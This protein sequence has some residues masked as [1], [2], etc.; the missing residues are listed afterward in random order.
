[1]LPP[2]KRNSFS[3]KTINP[4]IRR[5][6]DER[7]TLDNTQ[8][9]AMPFVKATTTVKLPNILGSNSVG[10]TLGVQTL[11]RDIQLRDI[12][13]GVD[14]KE[15]VGYT[16][17]EQ[18]GGVVTKPIFAEQL[19]GAGTVNRF[20]DN[21]EILVNDSRGF[22]FIPPPGITSVTVGTNRQGF[23]RF[24][25][26]TISI[27]TRLQLEMLHRTFLLPGCGLVLEW[28]QQFAPKEIF[29]FGETGLEEIELFPWYDGEAK[30]R[31]YL[32]R[33]GKNQVGLDEIYEKYVIPSRG[34][35]NWTYGKIVSFNLNSNSDGSFE[36]KIKTVGSNENSLAY[37][38]R[39]TY[40][41]PTLGEVTLHDKNSIE[42]YFNKTVAGAKNFKSVL[43]R[44]RNGRILPEWRG[45]V[46]YFSQGNKIE[47]IS[48]EPVDAPNVDKTGFQDSEDA[49]FLTWRFF[50]NVILNDE[51]FGVKSIFKDKRLTPEQLERVS[52]LR[53][54][55]N[56]VG[57]DTDRYIVDP[58][59]N[60]V[61]NNKYL[62][63]I[64]PSTL[65]IVNETAAKESNKELI[66]NPI[67]EEVDV[68]ELYPITDESKAFLYSGSGDFYN[69]GDRPEGSNIQEVFASSLSQLGKNRDKGFLS[70]GVWINHKAVI[71]CILGAPTILEGINKLLQR[72][73]NATNNYWSLAIDE[74]DPV[75]EDAGNGIATNYGIVDMN[76]ADSS[77]IAVN[78]FLK[79]EET[80]VHVFNKYI[81]EQNG[82]IVG[83]DTIE[84]TVNLDLPKLLFSQ[85]S[86]LGITQPKDFEEFINNENGGDNTELPNDPYVPGANSIL[87]SI[88][89]I[90]ALSTE[91]SPEGNFD[92]SQ[93]RTDITRENLGQTT[94][95]AGISNAQL[96]ANVAGRGQDVAAPTLA[97]IRN[98]IAR[99]NA[100]TIFVGTSAQRTELRPELK[101]KSLAEIVNFEID[102]AR[103]KL[104]IC[105]RDCI[106]GGEPTQNLTEP[107]EES[108][109]LP[110]RRLTQ[111]T[112]AEIIAAQN[113]RAIFA[114][115][116]YQLIPI[117]FN[118]WVTANNID[119][120]AIFDEELQERAGDWLITSKRPKVGQYVQGSTS[121]SL[122]T[123][124]LEL[125]QEFASIP[126]P[127]NTRNDRGTQITAGESF[128]KDRANNRA[129]HTVGEVRDALLQARNSGNLQALKGFIG[130]GEGG[131]DSINIIPVKDGPVF[132]P[133][134]NTEN[135]IRAVN[136]V[137][138]SFDGQAP[139][140]RTQ[141]QPVRFLEE[142]EC[143]G[144]GRLVEK[145]A[146]LQRELEVVTESESVKKE[147][148]TFVE[149]YPY[150]EKLF[151]YIE[152]FPDFM[153]SQIANDANGNNA[154]AFG[155]APGSLSIKAS[156]TLP[157]ITGLR[158][159]ELFWI[160]RIP[161]FYK[162]FGAFMVLGLE[163]EISTSGWVTRI[164]A[165]FYYLGRSWTG[166]VTRLLQ[167][168]DI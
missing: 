110:N 62:R 63:S 75:A 148:E 145:I 104:E 74:S 23:V 64:D 41:T 146:Q 111:L 119:T 82:N 122:E 129:Q 9:I 157:G 80:K 91:N 31:S 59:E 112:V 50:V 2:H 154:N 15:L 105:E 106:D 57:E 29:N 131:Y 167:G 93:P 151:R 114:V 68:E 165:V 100:K 117:T 76:F 127:F 162:A 25:D 126:V 143:E 79:G 60:Y 58:Y 44:V 168:R 108:L 11:D 65:I 86:T 10:F 139:I 147:T 6:L 163:E 45:H 4:T 52:L 28:G 66:L 37:S 134:P 51:E 42:S 87:R 89:S 149:K 99:E 115:G 17:E 48:D 118:S 14:D 55:R 77:D 98:R 16:Y 140:S 69:S 1:M 33:L 124:Q 94:S 164:E 20:L 43:E 92:L 7:S 40:I 47:G 152:V 35:Y 133:R 72:M 12:Y 101:D 70:S 19:L 141:T 90:T 81:R 132:A 103:S 144:C 121:V 153:S 36:C 73:N 125:A 13:S 5:V 116:K 150:L 54:Y 95:N 18:S 56:T 26:I 156:L 161:T 34:Q 136:G 120:N 158:V 123:A 30:L 49:Y 83:S 27:P 135:Y 96:P 67:Y 142:G 155:A 128:Y 166:S 39:T 46:Q 32:E 109:E 88:F 71:Q 107:Q 159:G 78:E 138:Y 113:V 24:S 85:I 97:S 84:C 53:P 3:Y 38:V 160:D 21:E 61:G 137:P 8:Q 22:N 102:E 130:A